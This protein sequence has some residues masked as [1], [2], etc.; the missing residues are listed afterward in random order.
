MVNPSSFKIN[1]KSRIS[2]YI[3]KN[4]VYAMKGLV[5]FLLSN[6]VDLMF[7]RVNKGQLQLITISMKKISTDVH[8]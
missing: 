3:Y 8:K 6:I 4:W 1:G 5:S 2:W 7:G